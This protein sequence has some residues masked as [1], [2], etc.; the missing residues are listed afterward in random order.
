[1]I[2]K[3]IHSNTMPQVEPHSHPAGGPH[4]PRLLRR[5]VRQRLSAQV[6]LGREIRYSEE[7]LTLYAK[8]MPCFPLRPKFIP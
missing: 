3:L 2:L 1:M 4:G 5:G 7:I 6:G 8:G